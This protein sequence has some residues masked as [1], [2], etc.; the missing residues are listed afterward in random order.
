MTRIVLQQA[1]LEHLTAMIGEIPFKYAV[2][3]ANY[4]AELAAKQE[5]EQRKKEAEGKSDG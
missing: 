4:L 1:E 2:G 3:L 5:F